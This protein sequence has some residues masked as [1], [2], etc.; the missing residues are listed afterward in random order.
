[1]RLY[2]QK[3]REGEKQ[4]KERLFDFFVETKQSSKI[5]EGELP[6]IN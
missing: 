4:S 2:G 3:E 5:A 6:H 1:V